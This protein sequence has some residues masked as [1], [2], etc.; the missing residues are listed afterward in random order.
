MNTIINYL[1]NMFA[2]LPKSA[3]MRHLRDELLANME[4]KYHELKQVGKTE[5]E[6]VGIVISEFGNIDEIIEEFGVSLEED[7]VTN[8]LLTEVE[9]EEYLNTTRKS[10]RW[11]GIGVTL[12]ILGAAM[13][14]LL[15]GVI[16][17]GY[18]EISSETGTYL[19]LIVLLLFVAIAVGLFI[20]AGM[21]LEKY[22][23]ISFEGDFD[24]S[25]D[26]K[27]KVRAKKDAFQST[28]MIVMI[29]GVILIIFSPIVLFTMMAFNENTANFGV[30]IM[31][32]LVSI[33]VYLFVYFGNV[34]AAYEKLL[35]GKSKRTNEREEDRVIGAVAS[36]IWPLVVIIFLISGLVYDQWHINWIVFPVTG[37]LFAMFSGAYS[38]LVRKD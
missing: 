18:N 20:Y 16:E 33:A 25:M 36:I 4:E 10:G 24:L 38:I 19:G 30:C 27:N 32:V 9:V 7:R 29:V 37:L 2:S 5:N 22:K 8:P 11:I 35:R 12:C 21:K 31:L 34:Y 14:V 17:N 26:L 3:E 28:Y 13:L 1:D 15:L 23:F 6:A